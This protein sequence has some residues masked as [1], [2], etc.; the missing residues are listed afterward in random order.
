[1]FYNFA[2]IVV[3]SSYHFLEDYYEKKSNDYK[4]LLM[5]RVKLGSLN[6]EYLHITL[7]DL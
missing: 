7:Y 2:N 3:S 1:M 5:H 6:Y 4:N